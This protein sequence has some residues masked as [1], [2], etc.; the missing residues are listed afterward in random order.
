MTEQPATEQVLVLARCRAGDAGQALGLKAGDILVGLDGAPWRG[1]AVRLQAHILR[2]GKECALCFQRGE[3]VFTVLSARADLGQWRQ[4]APPEGGAA[5]PAC[6]AGLCNWEIMADRRGNHDLF[7]TVPGLLALIAP[8]IWLAQARLWPGLALFAAASAL[9][10]PVGWPLVACLWLAGGLHLWRDGASHQ[11]IALQMQGFR[12]A[13]IIAAHS[14]AEAASTWQA[15]FPDAKF[16]FAP[17]GHG[18]LS[19]SELG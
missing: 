13:G 6:R 11:R 5:V 1:S 10:M 12:R 3:A 8:P 15:I 4:I 7:A 9:C 2:A 18:P 19:A 14:E 17:Q 16:R